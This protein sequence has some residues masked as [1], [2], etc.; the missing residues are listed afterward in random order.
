[1]E[2]TT[3]ITWNALVYLIYYGLNFAYDYLRNRNSQLQ[4]TIQYSYKDLLEETPAKVDPANQPSNQASITEAIAKDLKDQGNTAS[5]PV[6][7]AGPVE[8]QGIPFEEIM[9]NAKSHSSNINF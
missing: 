3:L 8:D 2:I 6:T 7:L 5:S 4:K 1:M 9:Q